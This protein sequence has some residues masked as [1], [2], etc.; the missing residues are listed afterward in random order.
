[1]FCHKC[2]EKQS[3]DT[4]FCT[5]CGTP[6]SNSV[7][8]PTPSSNHNDEN[9]SVKSD[10]SLSD[11]VRQK[12]ISELGEPK[13]S[14]LEAVVFVVSFI[15]SMIIIDTLFGAGGWSL[16]ITIFIFVAAKY[17]LNKL[18]EENKLKLQ[19][20]SD[21]MLELLYNK[22]ERKRHFH[23]IAMIV[24]I[25][26]IVVLSFIAVSS[27]NSNIV[28]SLWTYTTSD[29]K[30][31]VVSKTAI[32]DSFI[33]SGE[34]DYGISV[35]TVIENSGKDG[36]VDVHV[37]LSSS[38]GEAL[39]QRQTV[40]LKAWETRSLHYQFVEP[41]VNAKNIEYSVSCLPEFEKHDNTE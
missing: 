11:D 41:T 27:E 15:V 26:G 10:R 25:I 34:P 32:D 28:K 21:D 40:F 19:N 36:N 9:D 6:T 20:H 29:A 2:G 1:M 22:M 3:D 4:K 23:N 17:F 14:S 13:E 18:K 8:K 24:V 33:I 7:V 12:Y 37:H 16:L 38:E 31:S 35:Y 39:V 30:C 5:N